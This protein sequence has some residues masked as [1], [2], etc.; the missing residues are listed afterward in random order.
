[1]KKCIKI[2]FAISIGLTAFLSYKYYY[3]LKIKSIATEIDT[4]QIFF[5]GTIN[6]GMTLFFE[7]HFRHPTTIE[8][9]D[10]K[11]YIE[12]YYPAIHKR[13]RILYYDYHRY[14]VYRGRRIRSAKNAVVLWRN[15]SEEEII[16]LYGEG[17]VSMGEKTTNEKLKELY[18]LWFGKKKPFRI[19][20]LNFWNYLWYGRILL[21]AGR[22]MQTPCDMLHEPNIDPPP[23]P[24]FGL[25]CTAGADVHVR[26]KTEQR[27]KYQ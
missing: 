20:E 9:L 19:K 4:V 2:L 27:N 8:E 21:T 25:G 23:P 22:L 13:L 14:I 6:S 11:V 5:Y 15:F 16:E 24:P 17:G 18:E 7:T 12:Q 1:M 26:A 3:Y 10:I